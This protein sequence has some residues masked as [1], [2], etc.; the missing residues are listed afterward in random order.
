MEKQNKKTIESKEY[1]KFI[2]CPIWSEIILFI[3]ILYFFKYKDDMDN[4]W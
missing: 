4:K 2:N 3:L 1:T